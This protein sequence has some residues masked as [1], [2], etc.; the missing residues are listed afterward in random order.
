VVAWKQG[1]EW[2][3][4]SVRTAGS[5]AGLEASA[6]RSQ[7]AADG[8]DLAFVTV[9]V[10][11]KD[12]NTTPRASNLVKFSVDGPG[13]IVATDNGDPTSFVAFPSPQRPAFNGLCLVIVRAKPG[14][15]GE[16]RVRAESP[17]LKGTL[18]KLNSV[19]AAK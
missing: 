18:V 11:D 1:R 6:D 10:A 17:A 14:Q 12:G 5:A 4:S 3:T 7:I 13:E 15:A 8:L 2:A 9:R 16:I 19:A